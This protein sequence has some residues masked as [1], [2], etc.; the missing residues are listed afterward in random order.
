MIAVEDLLKPVSAEKPCGNEEWIG[1][2]EKAAAGKPEDHLG[3]TPAQDPNWKELRAMSLDSFKRSKHLTTSVIVTL[4]VM[5]TDGLG[6]LRDGLALVSGLLQS[7]WNQLHPLLDADDPDPTERINILNNLG[8]YGEPYRFVRRLEEVPLGHAE[9]LGPASAIKLKD[10]IAAKTPPAAGATPGPTE[11]QLTAVLRD[12]KPDTLKANYD[13]VVQAQESI[14][15]MESF[16]TTTLGA[17]QTPDLEHLGKSLKAIQNVLAPFV[18]APA[19]GEPAGVA[20][21][22]AVSMRDPGSRSNGIASR[23]DVIHALEQICEYYNRSEPA[24]PIPFIIKRAQ[25]MV[26]MN[27]M[28]IINELTPDS[29]TQVKVITGPDPAEQPPAS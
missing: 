19:E 11:A 12:A 17:G 6:G 13:A 1:E 2:L 27:F 14:K 20:A 9:K 5:K 25:R 4:A 22:G 7:Y 21:G 28:E 10:F 3:K 16:L 24:S 18:G 23:E 26:K 15:Q 29:I 8:S